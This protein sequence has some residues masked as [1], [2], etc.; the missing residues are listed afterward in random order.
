[1]INTLPATLPQSNQKTTASTLNTQHT[2]ALDPAAARSVPVHHLWP[3]DLAPSAPQAGSAGLRRPKA[4][5]GPGWVRPP[6]ERR[7][8]G[9]ASTFIRSAQFHVIALEWNIMFPV[10]SPVLFKSGGPVGPA[11]TPPQRRGA[12]LCAPR[13]LPVFCQPNVARVTIRSIPL[14]ARS[15]EE[16]GG[17]GAPVPR[18]P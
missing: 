4:S 18:R 11:P 17:Q 5:A 14:L 2:D 8:P 13:A 16:V 7:T 12:R 9:R 15:S 10:R 1:M 3:C 6:L